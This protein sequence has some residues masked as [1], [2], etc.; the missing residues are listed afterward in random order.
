M[1]EMITVNNN[2]TTKPIN[3]WNDFVVAVGASITSTC[4]SAPRKEGVYNEPSISF[5]NDGSVWASGAHGG[6]RM[7]RK[8]PPALMYEIYMQ[9]FNEVKGVS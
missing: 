1:K 3:D 7:F 8:C 4:I 6:V 9:R 2:N 5:D